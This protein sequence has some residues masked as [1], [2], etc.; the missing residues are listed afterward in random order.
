MYLCI[1]EINVPLNSKDAYVGLMH[2][3]VNHKLYIPKRGLSKACK[4]KPLQLKN[5]I[6]FM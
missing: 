2:L 4:D 1:K 6:S 5:G 3:L